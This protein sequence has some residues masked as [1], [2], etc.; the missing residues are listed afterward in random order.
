MR[1]T[2]ISAIALCFVLI[3]TGAVRADGSALPD[4]TGYW[5]LNLPGGKT[6]WMTLT[7]VDRRGGE[8]DP[9]YKGRIAL[10]GSVEAEIYCPLYRSDIG[11]GKRIYLRITNC[12]G[13]R[14]R[15]S[16]L[17]LTLTGADTVPCRLQTADPH[18]GDEARSIADQ[19][20]T[21]VRR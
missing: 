5:T 4:L 10:P 20:F 6:G 21:A 15:Y 16:Y 18:C 17:L 3:A 2:A 8:N 1:T 19:E 11:R 7:T 12:V 13:Q 9:V 14:N